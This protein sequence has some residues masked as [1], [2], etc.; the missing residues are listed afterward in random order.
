MRVSLSVR[1]RCELAWQNRPADF[2]NAVKSQHETQLARA[3]SPL[4]ENTFQG[5]GRALFEQT[6]EEDV[7]ELQVSLEFVSDDASDL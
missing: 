3:L 7:P 6:W 4:P 1:D 5:V 2:F